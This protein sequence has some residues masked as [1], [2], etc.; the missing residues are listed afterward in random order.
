MF[1]EDAETGTDLSGCCAENF[2]PC[3]DLSGTTKKVV[4]AGTDLAK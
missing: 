4:G 3:P 1:K 2:C